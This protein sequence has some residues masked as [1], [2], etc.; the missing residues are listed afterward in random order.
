MTLRALQVED[1]RVLASWQTDA[2]F[3]AHAG[4]RVTSDPADGE[5]WWRASILQ[6]DPLLLRLAVTE[7]GALVG[8]VDLYGARS[9][10]RELGFLIGPSSRWGRGL[11][12]SAASAALAHGFVHLRL[13]RVWAEAVAANHASVR[14]LK[15][16]GLSPAGRGRAE[17]FLGEPS[18]YER[19]EIAHSDWLA[20]GGASETGKAHDDA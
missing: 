6:P 8:F 12:T 18:H 2:V 4:W 3:A 14:V 20:T 5:Q 17:E 19:F 15:K 7:D 1:A 9:D 10:E 11:A 13:R 16:A